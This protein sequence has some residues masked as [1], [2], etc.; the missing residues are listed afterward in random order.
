MINTLKV[1]GSVGYLGGLMAVPEAFC[2]AWGHLVAFTNEYVCQDGESVQ[3]LKAS[4]SLHA[5][6]RNDLARRMLGDW[7][8]MLDCDEVFPPEVILQLITLH[9]RYR[10]PV[11][12]GVYRH[13]AKPHHPML[14]H[15]SEAQDEP[16]FV[17]ILEVDN[18]KPLVKVDAA[19]GGCLFVHR[20]VFARLKERFPKED[21]FDH[22]GRY[23]ED[24]SFFLRL[25][26]AGIPVYAAPQ[27]EV[28]HLRV[29]GITADDYEPEWFA[30][31]AQVQLV[32]VQGA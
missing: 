29:H 4:M 24:F 11:I 7:L 1:L 9:Q 30:D 15:W 18:T 28:T 16:G 26:E 10:A 23:G 12:S 8:V 21:P 22:R 13:K 3:Y 20:S 17:P 32:C 2:W 19:G 25:K 27:V 31:D 5:G 6:A 14:W